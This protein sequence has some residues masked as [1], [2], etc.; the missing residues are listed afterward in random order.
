MF[1]AGSMA[2]LSEE[3]LPAEKRKPFTLRHSNPLAFWAFFRQNESLRIIALLLVMRSMP[4]HNNIHQVGPPPEPQL[5]AV[6]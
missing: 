3:T 1:G 4:M 2:V 5:P 6:V